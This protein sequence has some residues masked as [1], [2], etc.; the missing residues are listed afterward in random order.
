MKLKQTLRLILPVFALFVVAV[1]VLSLAGSAGTAQAYIC[2]DPNEPTD[3]WEYHESDG[4]CWKVRYTNSGAA[5]LDPNTQTLGC[6]N[7][8]I[9][10]ADDNTCWRKNGYSSEDTGRI[11]PRNNDGTPLAQENVT[12]MSGFDYIKNGKDGPGCY[13]KGSNGAYSCGVNQNVGVSE[14]E[15]TCTDTKNRMIPKDKAQSSDTTNSE[16]EPDKAS[17]DTNYTRQCRATGKSEEECKKLLEAAQKECNL[18]VAYNGADYN[19]CLG[20]KTISGYGKCTDGSRPDPK[21]GQC[22]DGKPPTMPLSESNKTGHQC[23]KAETVLIDC[24]G[25]G[26]EAIAEILRIAVRILTIIIGIAAVGGLAWASIL[27]SKA[28]DSEGDTKEAKELI[29]NIVIGLLLY[30]FMVVIVNW[31]VP[32]GIIV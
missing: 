14:F 16:S 27:Y 31:L 9:L 5:K 3:V 25:T 23:G 17:A 6:P 28:Q 21:T 26:E 13:K 18:E 29:R 19:D 4:M 8:Q 15:E 2:G 7:D 10:H 12:C 22:P 1:G 24:T 30:G 20:R 11:A 32:G